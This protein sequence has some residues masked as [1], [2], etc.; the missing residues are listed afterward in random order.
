MLGKLIESAKFQVLF[1]GGQYTDTSA[2][3][4]YGR[5]V[6]TQGY[7]EAVF[8]VHANSVPTTNTL[9]PLLVENSIADPVG[10]VAVTSASFTALSA[11]NYTTPQAGSIVCKNTKRFLFLKT[12]MAAGTGANPTIG[13]GAIVVLSKAD[14]EPVSNGPVFNIDNL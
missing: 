9:T 1:P 10:A 8:V 14:R 7:D 2:A 4:C 6:D 12:T 13:F 5:P 3:V 11:S